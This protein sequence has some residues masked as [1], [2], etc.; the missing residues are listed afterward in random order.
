MEQQKYCSWDVPL[1]ISNP[2]YQLVSI[3]LILKICVNKKSKSA[4]IG[5]IQL[6]LWGLASKG[7]VEEL[8][9]IRLGKSIENI[10]LYVDPKIFEVVRQC[11]MDGLIVT[12]NDSVNSLYYLARKGSQML[13]TLSETDLYTDIYNSLDDI[14]VIPE[15]KIKNLKINWY[16]TI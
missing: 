11:V 2:L 6:Y 9:S 3:L 7:N 8:K 4:S 16:A 15:T 14:G 10:P 1:F 5:R 13:D 12:G